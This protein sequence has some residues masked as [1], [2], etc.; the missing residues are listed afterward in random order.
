MLQLKMPGGKNLFQDAWLREVVENK[1]GNGHYLKKWCSRDTIFNHNDYMNL[2]GYCYVISWWWYVSIATANILV[3]VWRHGISCGNADFDLWC[4]FT[5][6][7]DYKLK[8]I[9]LCPLVLCRNY[10][11]TC[12]I[13]WKRVYFQGIIT[14]QIRNLCSY[15]LKS[16]VQG[17]IYDLSVQDL[18]MDLNINF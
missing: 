9:K 17:S 13:L 5:A 18:F 12:C 3:P 11:R 2:F 1:D 16:F 14:N 7:G 10:C 6:L 15:V 8:T 4:I